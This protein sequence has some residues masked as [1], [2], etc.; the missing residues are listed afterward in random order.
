[1]RIRGKVAAATLTASLA[2]AAAAC[3]SSTSGGIAQSGSTSSTGGGSSGTAAPSNAPGVTPTEIRVGAISTLTGTLA[4]N[5]ESLVP[6][7]QAYFDYVNAKGGV[8]GRKLVM[9]SSLDDGGN[10][11]QF[12]QLAQ[13]LINQDHVFA[14]VGVATAFFS[15]NIFVENNIPT[16]GYD[17]TGNWSGAPNLFAAGGSVQCTKCGEPEF[18][19][20]VHK[21]QPTNA[22][23]GLLALGF[24]SSANSCKAF[25]DGLTEAGV[26][27]GFTDFNVPYGGNPAPDVKRMQQAGVNTFIS[28]MDVNSNIAVARAMKQYGYTVKSLWLSGND[29]P[30]LDQYQDLMQ[31]VWFSIAHVPFS[32]ATS[33]PSKYPG[34]VTYFNAMKKYEPKWTLDEVALQGWESA[35]LFAQAVKAAGSNLTQANVI[36]ET[37]KIT[38]FTAGL[39]APVDWTREHD[40]NLVKPP[41][42]AAWIQVVGDKFVPVFDTNN[43]AFLCFG[44]DVAHPTMVSPPAGTPGA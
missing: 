35:A 32:Y 38:N 26:K 7:V 11:S 6:G 33:A 21:V 14:V 5:F 15:P 36:A 4:S 28:C 25:N 31:N 10:P 17:V 30:T 34:L 12:N 16:Y 41:Y 24:A 19:W 44:P 1:M 43:S 37:N 22:N 13:T 39:F 29:Q 20:W 2:A 8:N 23:V 27:V 40:V 42:C 3:G 18:N 9:A